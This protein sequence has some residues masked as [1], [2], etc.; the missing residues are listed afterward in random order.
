MAYDDDDHPEWD[1]GEERRAQELEDLKDEL[2]RFRAREHLVQ[3]LLDCFD[4]D[5]RYPQLAEDCGDGYRAGDAAKA[6]R[7]FK[8][9][10]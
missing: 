9:T 3:A 8:V 2:K 10:P 7:D 6:V 1:I 5:N 4:M